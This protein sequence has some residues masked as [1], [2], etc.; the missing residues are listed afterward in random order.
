MD[1]RGTRSI[2]VVD[3]NRDLADCQAMLL[4]VAGYRVAVAYDGRRAVDA[5]LAGRPDV[6]LLDIGLPGLDGYEVA[7]RLRRDERTAGVVIVAVSAFDPARDAARASRPAFD[8]RLVKP[9][10][11]DELLAILGG[12]AA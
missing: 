10:R 1:S 8:F 7:E 3:D 11:F 6:V 12:L 5:A 2:L 4:E 9:L